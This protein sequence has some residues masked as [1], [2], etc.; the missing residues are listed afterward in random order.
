MTRKINID[1]NCK[2]VFEF[3]IVTKR[4]IDFFDPEFVNIDELKAVIAKRIEEL[5]ATKDADGNITEIGGE[6]L[7]IDITPN[8]ICYRVKGKADTKIK[9][10]TYFIKECVRQYLEQHGLENK[11]KSNGGVFAGGFVCKTIGKGITQEDIDKY[12]SEI[13]TKIKL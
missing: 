12:R 10:Y 13:A 3:Y 7:S 5:G 1:N 6:L 8:A 11:V 4:G 2:L 9:S